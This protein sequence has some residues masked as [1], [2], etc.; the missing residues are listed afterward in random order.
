MK[1]YKDK[2]EQREYDNVRS[3]YS[4]PHSKIAKHDEHR[5]IL[6]NS[7]MKIQGKFRVYAMAKILTRITNVLRKILH[8]HL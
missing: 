1:H 4:V 8:L 7:I 3:E 5:R 6:E 2:Q